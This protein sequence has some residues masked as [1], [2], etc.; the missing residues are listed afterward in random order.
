MGT[1]NGDTHLFNERENIAKS[2][3]E[4]FFFHSVLSS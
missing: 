1:I 4:G 2:A 3:L